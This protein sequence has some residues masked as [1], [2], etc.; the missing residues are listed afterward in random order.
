MVQ[1]CWSGLQDAYRGDQRHLHWC[2][3]LC[4]EH[5]TH[6]YAVLRVQTRSAP[7]LATF[8]FAVVS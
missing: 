6:L 7:S 3:C 8:P 5:F 4:S 2:V 1:G